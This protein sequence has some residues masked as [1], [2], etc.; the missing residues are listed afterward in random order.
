MEKAKK[1][2]VVAELRSTMVSAP[3]VIL[4]SSVGLPVNVVNDLRSKLRAQGATYR[5]V[6]NTLAKRAI[7]G[8][9]MEALADLFSGPVGVAFH[10]DDVTVA[11][12]VV[13]DFAKDR[14]KFVVKAGYLNGSLLDA[15]GVEALSKMPG[16]D[17]LRAD[18][19]RVMNGVGTKFVRVLAAGPTSFLN[20]LNARRDSLGA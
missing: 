13:T 5:V 11:A 12:K 16:K 20:V 1:E 3:S 19:L 18:L 10:P 7:E 14:E 2:E 15:A 17:E 8:T 4:A 9:P 6:K